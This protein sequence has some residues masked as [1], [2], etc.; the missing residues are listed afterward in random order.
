MM[1][2]YYQEMLIVKADYKD[3]QGVPNSLQVILFENSEEECEQT[4][5]VSGKVIKKQNFTKNRY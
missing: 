5:L 4:Q 1:A 3:N 2:E